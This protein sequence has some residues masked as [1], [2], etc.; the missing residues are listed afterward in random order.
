M[1]SRQKHAQTTYVP[2]HIKKAQQDIH[3]SATLSSSS[4]QESNRG[5]CRGLRVEV[6]SVVCRAR[7]QATRGALRNVWA[8]VEYSVLRGLAGMHE[9]EALNM[10]VGVS[11]HSPCS[12]SRRLVPQGIQ[13]PGV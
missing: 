5:S 4:P 6:P 9:L 3:R 13:G 7:V 11:R 8:E 12:G 10:S 2:T 1:Y